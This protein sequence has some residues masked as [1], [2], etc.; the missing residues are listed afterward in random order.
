VLGVADQ[1]SVAQLADPVAADVGE[2][3]VGHMFLV[4]HLDA[5]RHMPGQP[6]RD[7]LPPRGLAGHDLLA[8]GMVDAGGGEVVRVQRFVDHERVGSGPEAA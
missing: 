1:E 6:G 3:V 5:R 7:R 4:V 8:P 2:Q